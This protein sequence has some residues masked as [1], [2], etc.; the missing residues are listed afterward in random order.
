MKNIFSVLVLV[1]WKWT[2]SE[3][4]WAP[5]KGRNTENENTVIEFFNDSIIQISVNRKL[6]GVTNWIIKPKDGELYGLE[7][8]TTITTLL[9]GRILI[10]GETLESNNSYIDGSDNYFIK[11]N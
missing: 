9:Y 8:D 5:D 1:L 10:C 6:I 4:F 11:F 3:N 2:Y 7:L